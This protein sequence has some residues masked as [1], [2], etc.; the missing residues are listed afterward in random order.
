MVSSSND[1]SANS[2]EDEDSAELP[3]SGLVAPWEVLRGLAEAAAEISAKASFSS[4]QKV[5]HK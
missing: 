5:Y 4:V 2:S 1:T 3:A